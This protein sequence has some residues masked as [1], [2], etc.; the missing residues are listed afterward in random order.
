VFDEVLAGSGM[1]I[2]KTPVRSPGRTHSRNVMRG[3][4]GASAST[5]C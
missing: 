2:I 1:R 4:C 3:R 5:T